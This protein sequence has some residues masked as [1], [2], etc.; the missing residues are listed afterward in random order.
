MT[1]DKSRKAF[2]AWAVSQGMPIDR[3]NLGYED[4]A[5]FLSWESWQASRADILA[6]LESDKMVE[7]AAN[8]LYMDRHGI[9]N[10]YSR[11]ASIDDAKAAIA[12]IVKEIK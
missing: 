4:S 6:L 10:G 8:G 3:T 11:Q 2:E 7:V 9:M 1:Q 12:T 5:V